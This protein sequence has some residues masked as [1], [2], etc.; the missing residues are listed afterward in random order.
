MTTYTAVPEFPKHDYTYSIEQLLFEQ[1]T[2]LVKYMPVNTALPSVTINIPIWP[3]LDLNNMKPYLDNWA[4]NDKWF[5]QEM[6]LN[7][8]DS[9]LGAA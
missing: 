6:I 9:L 1:G 4:P 5:A 7:N 2:M 8:G 3:G